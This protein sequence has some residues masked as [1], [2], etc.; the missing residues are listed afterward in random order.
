MKVKLIKDHSIRGTVES[1]DTIVDI[2]EGVA[3]DLIE[4]GIAQKPSKP[5]AEKPKADK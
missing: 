2:G 3:Q 5:K 1:A 4:R